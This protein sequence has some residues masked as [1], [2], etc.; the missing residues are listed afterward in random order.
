VN[1][2][3]H[4]P[5]AHECLQRFLQH[6]NSHGVEQTHANKCTKCT[7]L[8]KN[9]MLTEQHELVHDDEH[10]AKRLKS[11]WGVKRTQ[12]RQWPMKEHHKRLFRMAGM[13]VD[14]MEQQVAASRAE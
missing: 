14:A 7:Y 8:Y 12:S 3:P 13:D 10:Q 1:F 9:A 11:T 5:F 6:L 4:C 2:C